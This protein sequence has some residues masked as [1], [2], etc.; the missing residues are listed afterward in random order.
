MLS[1]KPSDRY[2]SA[3][4]V[5]AALEHSDTTIVSQ[6][7]VA[8][9]VSQSTKP[10]IKA[11]LVDQCERELVNYIG[12]VARFLIQEVLQNVASSQ[13]L[14]TALAAKIPNSQHAIEFQRK[15]SRINA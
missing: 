10:A 3:Q 5:L 8:T 15:L 11:V 13:A 2:A 14:I 6:A 9:A 1:D 7:P 4:E 12:P